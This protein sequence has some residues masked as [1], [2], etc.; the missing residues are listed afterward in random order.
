MI[1]LG[2][3]YWNNR[4][5][6]NES[7]WDAGAI[8]TPLKE[9][10]DTLKNADISI[11][12]PGAGNAYEAEYLFN[13]GFKNVTVVDFAREPLKNIK[14]RCPEFPDSKLIQD[15]F[16]KYS[17][18]FDLII[19]QTFFCAIEPSLRPQYAKHMHSL[20][21]T[22][23]MLAGVLFNDTLNANHPP[24]GGSKEEYINYFE[25]YFKF[26]TFE[27][28]Y[29]SIKPRAGRELFIRLVKK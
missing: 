13:K 8:T 25:P 18:K 22:N 1:D 23:G 20:L 21:N 16:F 11:L 4:Y 14:K 29:H 27:T 6:N 5:I 19:E 7:G 24:F 9:F 12:I 3:E 28:C 26:K 2:K 15:D 10:F 17:G